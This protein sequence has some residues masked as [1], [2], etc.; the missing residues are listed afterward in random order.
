MNFL[1]TV[2][3]RPYVLSHGLLPNKVKFAYTL[4]PYSRYHEPYELERLLRKNS[5]YQL[6]YSPKRQLVPI[7]LALKFPLIFNSIR[8]AIVTRDR[9]YP[10]LLRKQE[11]VL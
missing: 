10:Q 1:D 5:S 2:R 8:R 4:E 6:P 9:T 7:R 11:R 3:I